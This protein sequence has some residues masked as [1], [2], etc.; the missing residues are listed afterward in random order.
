MNNGKSSQVRDL[1]RPVT[2]RSAGRPCPFI[3]KRRTSGLVSLP[4]VVALLA[5][6]AGILSASAQ[7]CS[8]GWFKVAG[9]GGTS[10][11]GGYSLSGTIGQPDAGRM[12]GGNYSIDGGFWGIMA[13]VQTAG[14]PWLTVSR[15]GNSVI[16]SWPSPSAGYSLQQSSGLNPANWSTFGGTISDNGTIKSVTS[17]TPHGNLFFR[18]SNP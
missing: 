3:G 12:S 2:G 11:G 10:T 4:A 18:L 5:L 16:I 8:I 9:G 14:T 1:L 7:S 17:S 6:L 13:A 15:S